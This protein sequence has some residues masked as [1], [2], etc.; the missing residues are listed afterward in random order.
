[1]NVAELAELFAAKPL[2]AVV[3]V[4]IVTNATTFA[5]L[6]RELRNTI[7]SSQLYGSSLT[8]LETIHGVST[9]LQRQTLDQLE[10][11]REI[12]AAVLQDPRVVRFLGHLVRA[13]RGSDDD[14]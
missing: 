4:L 8:K 12:L 10:H 1:M 7:R 2:P 3:A 11:T 6:I 14:G 5:L 13:R 9:K